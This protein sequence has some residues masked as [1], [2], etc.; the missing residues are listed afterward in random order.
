MLFFGYYDKNIR[1]S[2]A[3][4]RKGHRDRRPVSLAV[5]KQKNNTSPEHRKH[6][7]RAG[8]GPRLQNLSGSPS[9]IGPSARLCLLNV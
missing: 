9:G 4:S 7:K 8:S 1:I 2:T 6:R 3:Y 5:R